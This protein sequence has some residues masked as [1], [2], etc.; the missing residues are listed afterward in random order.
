MPS[1]INLTSRLNHGNE[2]GN[3]HDRDC[4]E[5]HKFRVANA[6]LKIAIDVHTDFDC[7][8]DLDSDTD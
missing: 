8:T 6:T 1:G 5:K 2:C 4:G 7:D 3:H